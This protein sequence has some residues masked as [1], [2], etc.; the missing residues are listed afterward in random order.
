MHVAHRDQASLLEGA[1][2]PLA[3]LEAY[4]SGKEAAPQVELLA[5]RQEFDRSRIEPVLVG[6]AKPERKPVRKIHEILVLDHVTGEIGAQPVV[7]AAEVGTRIVNAV[8][9]RPGGG[10]ARREIAIPQGAQGFA[11]TLARRVEALVHQRPCGWRFHRHP[12]LRQITHNDIG[13]GVAQRLRVSPAIDTDDAPESAGAS[14]LDAGDRVLHDDGTRRFRTDAPR[15]LHESIRCRL[16]LEPESGDV[17][18]VHP[19]VEQRRDTRRLQHRRAVVAGGH[20]GG[21][22]LLLPEFAHQ[23]DRRFI[24][25]DAVPLQVLQEIPVLQIAQ[26][27]HALHVGAV[28]GRTQRQFDSA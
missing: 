14:R 18:P 4:A 11:D 24:G 6:D 8:R 2:P 16:A 15:R 25:I 23:R 10:T 3:V 27:A 21:L 5:V 20:D 13:A 12:D 7:A 28:F 26:R 9:N 1:A 19:R 17:R 22:D